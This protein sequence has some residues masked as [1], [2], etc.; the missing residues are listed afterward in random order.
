MFDYQ[1]SKQPHFDTACRAFAQS[2]NLAELADCAGMQSQMLRN[3]LNPEQPHR[4]TCTDLLVLTDI[5]EDPTLLDGLLAQINCLPAVP[6]NDVKPE[7]LST[8]VL[9]ATAAVGEIASVAVS[10]ERMTQSSRARTESTVNA[11][12]RTALM[13]GLAV[14]SRYNASAPTVAAAVDMFTTVIHSGVL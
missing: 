14:E 5:T 1:T 2:H 8:C 9:S 4:L 12:I 3:K 11:L 13:I 6:M 10:T 7:N